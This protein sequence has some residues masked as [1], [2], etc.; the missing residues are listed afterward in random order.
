MKNLLIFAAFILAGLSVF[1]QNL[2]APTGLTCNLLREPSAAVITDPEPDFGWIFPQ[3]GIKQSAYRILVA[4]SPF[5]LKEGDANL[6]DTQ[7]VASNNS[8][9]I[10][11]SGKKLLPNSIYWWVVKVWSENGTE[12]SYSTPQQFNTGN[13][14]RSDVNYPGESR[15]VEL[16]GNDWVSEDKQCATLQQIAPV[17]VV[18][19]AAGNY[20]VVFEKSVIGTLEFT[21]TAENDQTPLTIH[22]G[23]RKND[24]QTVNKNSGRSNIGYQK[25]EM[26]LK[27][28][29]HHYLVKLKEREIKGYLHT[30][31]L[32]PHYPEVLPFRYAEI[33]SNETTEF[34]D[35]TQAALFYYFDENASAYTSSDERLNKVWDLCKY[36][37][38]STPFLGVYCDGNR[39]RMPY[40]ADAYIQMMSHFATDREYSIARYTINFLLD[41]ASWP[42]E[43]QMH[44]VLMAWE[45]YMQTGDKS[46]LVNR[47]ED[48]KRKSLIGLT[49]DSG[50]I[51]TRTGLKTE[52]YLRTLNF[53][54]SL[55][56]FRDIVDW[57]Q[58][59]KN[60]NQQASNQSP[61]AGG[62][63]DN[64]VYT[65]YNTVVNAFHNRSLVLM[66][67]IAQV[68][69]NQK[70]VEYFTKRA[71]EHHK[72]FYETFF[73]E[74]KGI[75]TDGESTDHSSLHANM[76]PMAFNMVEEKDIPAV[77]EFI[78]SRGMACSVYGSQYLLEALYAAGEAEHAFDLMTSV[79]KRSWLNMLRVGSTMTTE[80]WDEL[81]KPNLTW[82]HAWGSAPANITARKLMGI[83]PLEPTFSTFR[84]CPQPG[85]L[86]NA[87][88]KVPSIRGTIQCSI[89]N[90]INS[91]EM[92]VSIPG[93]TDAEIW[94][95]A[96]FTEIKVDGKEVIPFKSVN[97][98]M[99]IRNIFSLKSGNYVIVAKE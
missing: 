6:W 26:L 47:Y 62:E 39:E 49:D 11:Y 65:D 20:F 12:S 44:M 75:F 92:Q 22:L 64:Y 53:P 97:Y 16:S 59:A 25:I 94:L 86:E 95:P 40:E 46:L 29:T 5:L 51:S 79:G 30:Q 35:F 76:F 84:I 58:G 9:S 89:K 27:K 4:S 73:N 54:G 57:P 91:W 93:N 8:V 96:Q 87:C 81:F 43:W 41:H 60:K 67:E 34:S 42:T 88:I 61:F 77:A 80:A 66:S 52:A 50:L 21:A 72:I 63:T 69:G 28:G 33:I 23:E 19:N 13:F 17:N 45:Y 85:R 68:V 2:P 37:Q 18:M 99:G 7:K 38:K 83:E 78:K 3:S 55:Q 24:D 31:K 48:L 10:N 74:E 98:A 36:T 15:W 14:D 71:K 1:A 70:D 56:Q 90:D 32:A 82:N